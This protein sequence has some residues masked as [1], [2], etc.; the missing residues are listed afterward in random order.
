MQGACFKTTVVQGAHRVKS[1]QQYARRMLQD[2]FS[3]WSIQGNKR[4]AV[5]KVLAS[6]LL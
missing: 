4:E 6:R 3:A 5:C 1:E 2:Y